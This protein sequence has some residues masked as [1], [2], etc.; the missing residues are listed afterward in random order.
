MSV[1][2]N[3]QTKGFFKMPHYNIL[4]TDENINAANK[5]IDELTTEANK[6]K[7]DIRIHCGLQIVG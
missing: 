1:I 3:I 2:K 6:I 5:R 7:G 4:P